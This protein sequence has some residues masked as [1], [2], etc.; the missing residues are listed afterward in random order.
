MLS[1]VF[2]AAVLAFS[3]HGLAQQNQTMQ[4]NLRG[5]AETSVTCIPVWQECGSGSTESGCCDGECIRVNQWYSQC[6]PPHM[7]KAAETPSEKWTR[8]S[9]HLQL[10]CSGEDFI[11]CFNF[12][13]GPDPTDGYVDY[14]DRAEAEDMN[15]YEVTA[16]GSVRLGSIVGARAPAKSIRLQSKH[17]FGPGYVFV[18]DLEHIPTGMGTWPAWWAAGPHWPDNGEIDTI[19]SVHTDTAIFTTLHTSPGCSQ[20]EVQEISYE[21]DCNSGDG[22]DGCGVTGPPNSLS[23]GGH[24]FF[25]PGPVPGGTAGEAFNSHGGGVFATRWTDKGVDIW[26]F[27]RDSIPDDLQKNDSIDAES[28]G[29][30]YVKFPFGRN[31]PSSHFGDLQMVINLDFCGSWA[32]STFPGGA[33]ACKGYVGDSANVNALKEAYWLIR[34]V[35]VFA[36]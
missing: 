18:I 1:I 16:D 31:C 5:L 22:T 28:W 20:A 7:S 32:G 11:D 23:T 12:F 6:Q 2:L 13:T 29:A 24:K 36:S 10:D 26:Y 35:R 3:T 25:P 19:E 27:P 30:P 8:T 17:H 4:R 15:I 33:A 14:V 21:G 9:D 34:S